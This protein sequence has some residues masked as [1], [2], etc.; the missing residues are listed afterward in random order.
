MTTPKL[1]SYRKTGDF[2][3][4]G[5]N[6]YSNHAYNTSEPIEMTEKPHAGNVANGS[7]VV[8][9]NSKDR[10]DS[11]S[12]SSTKDGDEEKKDEP[13]KM[14][15]VTQV[16]RYSDS[17]DHL[18]IAVGMICSLIHGAAMPLMI[19]VFGDMSDLFVYQSQYEN[20]VNYYWDFYN[21]SENYP[22]ASKD[23]LLDDP[24]MAIPI[25]E[26]LNRTDLIEEVEENLTDDFMSQMRQYALYYAIIGFSV[27]VI[28]YI[29]VVCWQSSSYRQAQRIRT[30]L[31]RAIL[32]QEI[33]WFDTHEAGELNTRLAADVDKIQD[34]IGEKLGMFF[35]FIAQFFAGFIIGFI[36][37]WELTLVILAVSPL[38]AI[39]GAFMAKLGSTIA[40]K[41][42]K[43]YAK[44][45]AVA[46]EVLGSIRTVMAFGGQYK[47]TDRYRN[48]LFDARNWGV[49][50]GMVVGT[51]MGA[52]FFI[53]FGSYALA[54][55][56]GA[57][58]FLTKD[59]SAGDIL[60]V[61]FGVLIG[62]FSIG[63]AAPNIEN[64]ANARGAAYAL[65]E[66]IDLIPSIDSSS[67]EGDKHSTFKG[68]I[69]FRNVKFE[70]PSR[71]DV[72][73]LT[74]LN[75]KVDVG[76]TVA[77]V[78][79]S[80]CGKST[81]V[82]LLQRYYDPSD[83]Q[84]LIDGKD[85]REYNVKWLRQH[86]GVVSQEPVLF[87]TTIEENIRFGKD[88]VSMDEIIKACKMANAHNFI[89]ELP[90]KYKTLVGERGA[91][92]SGG[93]KQRIAIARALVRDPKI[94]L[95]D[96]ATSALDTESEAVVQ[97]ALDKAREGRTTIVIAHRLST[98][99]TA[100]QIAGIDQGKI[101][102]LGSH[103]E[104]MKTGGIYYTL[105]TNQSQKKGDKDEEDDDIEVPASPI[106]DKEFLMR[107][108]SVQS[109]QSD[110]T[111]ASLRKR[112]L[113]AGSTKEDKK[114]EEE[115]EKL[116]DP[117]LKR[118]MQMN[119]SE[120][121]F[122]LA[123]CFAA[124]INGGIQPGFA[125]VFSEILGVFSELDDEIIEERSEFYSL[126]FLC[127]GILAGL[128][129]F[130]MSTCFSRS[131]EY[132]TMRVREATFHALLRQEASYFDD[133][134]HNTGSLCARLSTDAS[135]VQGAT[136]SQLA[137]IF[138]SMAAILIALGIGFVFSWQLTLLI[139]A[140]A[141]FMLIAGAMQM[142]VMQGN[143]KADDEAMLEAGKIAI[144]AIENIRTVATLTKEDK[145]YNDYYFHTDIPTKQNLKRAHVQGMSFGFSQGVIF[146]AYAACFSY[147]AY[148]VSEKG[149]PYEDMFKVIMAIA[150]AAMSIGR[151][152]SYAPDLGKAKQAAARCFALMDS[153]PP[154]DSFSQ[155]GDKLSD[156]T[157]N[158]TFSNVSFNYPTRPD[159]PVLKGIDL[160][161][162][163]GQ[164]VA[165]V[166]SSGCGKSTIV[167][168]VERFYD[169]LQGNV[170]L[171][172]RDIK[173]LHIQ[174]YRSQMGIVSQEPV[175][176]DC[177][178]KDN[179]AY[180]DNSREVPMHEIIQAAKNANIHSFIESLPD[181]YETNVGDKGTQ[182][183]GGQKQRVAIARA[184]VRNPKILL[185]D[186][187][188]S[189]L[190][191]ESEKIVQEALDKAQKG[192]TSIVIAHRL[193]TVQ[194]ADCILVVKNGLVVESGTH[195]ELLKKRG[196]YYKL[197]NAQLARH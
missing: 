182:L 176:F 188:T 162:L 24:T 140:F 156:Y 30:S 85:L 168:L 154:I 89:S 27:W 35:Q 172:S 45:G 65:F 134:K 114:E 71:N 43:A 126:M 103:D 138:Q 158:I 144:E 108:F 53:M 132:L 149:L 47:E 77:L 75:L 137:T 197:N 17:V 16:F 87:Q 93:Q 187:A 118:I 69:E 124:I 41:E 76:Q 150:M 117:P 119:A 180:G 142:K 191:T 61:F 21:I 163:Q 38:L 9:S 177:S 145:F 153:E 183:S 185:L 74:G 49:K 46:E 70:Y 11:G 146:F 91:Q 106:K 64:F 22:N 10:H 110:R 139:C 143:K 13:R 120:W 151:F 52:I 90:E 34:G 121:P 160:T 32:R 107:S 116:P 127:I 115:E 57:Q 82:Q 63:N 15:G 192:R 157:S 194:N 67:E 112:T 55:W 184:L 42:L 178:I 78:G 190:D 31:F 5:V 4:S 98:V 54:F 39:S 66:I 28:G 181:G 136:G 50:K 147:G 23:A 92:L 159:I 169:P 20:W 84:V 101:A 60:V 19:I 122:I 170:G 104:L 196:F 68:N 155:E 25:L 133:P 72:P 56:Y 171:D 18:L 179:I 193:S 130:V 79:P 100:N 96:E 12:S 166:G 129:M 164:T 105:C 14:V 3:E 51:S 135:A 37:G 125:Y 189:A 40:A 109:Q 80:G 6:G 111:R 2:T 48:N 195:E 123:G 99:R 44:A 131:G 59:Y 152:S 26:A 186:E 102:E 148:L 88:D 81:T 165:L 173:N 29:Q 97:A 7:S 33:G 174:W 161:V 62:A 73:I 8:A 36:Y 1:A 167:Q 94:L 58:L 128:S 83:G 141:P 86:I 113:S 175:L 95:L